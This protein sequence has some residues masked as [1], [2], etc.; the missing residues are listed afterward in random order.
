MKK[1]NNFGAMYFNFLIGLIISVVGFSIILFSYYQLSYSG[2][3]DRQVCHNS[4]IFRATLPL[5]SNYLPL[6]C[7][8]EKICISGKVIGK[9]DCNEF[10]NEKSYLTMRVSNNPESLEKI[11]RIY[12]REILS[13]WRA[14]GEGKVSLFGGNLADTFGIKSV[15][16]SCVVCSRIA[17]DE[18]S[19]DKISFNEMDI[20]EY[21]LIHK[22]LETDKTYL[23]LI[24]SDIK[25]GFTINDLDVEK[26]NEVKYH[27]GE[28]D[29]EK[30]VGEVI[31]AN[32]EFKDFLIENNPS[33][34]AIVFMQITAPGH[35]SSLKN[36]LISAFGLG[37]GTSFATR[38]YA[39]KLIVQGVKSAPIIASV[40]VVAGIGAQQ[41]NV[42]YNRA[43][44]ATNCDDISI[45]SDA[46]SGCS[47][48]RTMN[49]D[50]SDIS[51]YCSIIESIP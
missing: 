25:T 21:M 47:V 31:T 14:M 23:E 41:I 27:E 44:T 22:A 33:E 38:G 30:E 15:Y 40:A 3:I 10:E 2:V 43:F 46:R 18:G 19:L 24:S 11:E 50:I 51:Q 26:L 16:P 29:E 13:C 32:G 20:Y 5:G 45:G 37:I 4:V 39:G 9:G 42:A 12:A 8:T 6:K 35:G 17:V 34:T 28:G 7:A 49:Y 36:S 1:K 48:V